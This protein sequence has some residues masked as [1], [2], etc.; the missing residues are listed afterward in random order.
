MPTLYNLSAE[1]KELEMALQDDELS[2][3]DRAKLI[4]DWLAAQDAATDKIEDYAAL[5]RL[6]ELRIQERLDEAARIR[7]EAERIEKLAKPDQKLTE[8]LRG[9][10]L[11]YLQ[12]H[13]ISRF[14]TT[15]FR[16]SVKTKGG[17]QPVRFEGELDELPERFIRIIPEKKEL[18][19]EELYRALTA[20]EEVPG[21]RLE[22][23]PPILEIK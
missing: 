1:I 18:D 2:Q 20:G 6:T 21:A 13:D 12:A 15:R 3:E 9:R 14:E 11:D 10:L 23:R 8:Q 5:I 22:E 19:K 4:D 16:V 7:A 17:K